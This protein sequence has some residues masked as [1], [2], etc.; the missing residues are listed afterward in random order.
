M[1][2]LEQC[3]A[4]TL[5]SDHIFGDTRTL[6]NSL[7]SVGHLIRMDQRRAVKVFESQLEE[8]R[9]TGRTRLRWLEDMEKDL[10]EMKV[11]R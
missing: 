11:K 6:K 4:D 1:E 10:Q 9:R 2:S 8:S 5:L 3:V 7:Y